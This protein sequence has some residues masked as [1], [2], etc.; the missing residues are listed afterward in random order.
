M[1]VEKGKLKNA[2]NKISVFVDREVNG[3]G[4][5][6]LFAAK[7]GVVS[8]IAGDGSNVGVFKFKVADNSELAFVIEHKQLVAA[9]GLRGDI[10]LEYKEGVLKIVQGDTTMIFAASDGDTFAFEEKNIEDGGCIKLNSTKFK[11]L[12]SKVSYARKEKDSRPFVTGVNLSFDGTNLK[13]ESTDALR[14]LRDFTAVEGFGDV[15]FSGV[16]SPKCIKA[17]ESMDDDVEVSILMNENAVG[18]VSE[19]MKIYLPKLNC[20][21]PDASR[22]FIFEAAATFVLDKAKVLESMEILALSEN[23]ALLC[24][25]V[26]GKMLFSMEDGVSDVKDK[27]EIESSEGVDF[28]FCLDFEIFRDIFRNL[29]DSS[30]VTFSWKDPLSTVLFKDEENL[31]GVVMP[32]KK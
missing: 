2:L 9:A 26:E 8:L 11:K 14:F 18:F 3:V 5:K 12:I 24:K 13:A 10:T 30:K 7:D 16:L 6:V 29:K 20:P 32:L 31:E 25:K 4:S 27:I 28:E 1:I 21:Y 15:N 23:K 22:F 19:D 17:I